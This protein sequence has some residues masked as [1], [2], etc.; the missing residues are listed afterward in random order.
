MS[1][2]T[3]TSTFWSVIALGLTVSVA[4]G[5]CATSPGNG[6]APTGAV[7]TQP[8]DPLATATGSAAVGASE[9]TAAPPEATSAYALTKSEIRERYEDW[10]LAMAAAVA[11][12]GTAS[13]V[14]R[15]ARA[16][17]IATIADDVL[18]WLNSHRDYDPKYSVPIT[19]WQN[20]LT[21]IRSGAR[22]VIK[23]LSAGDQALVAQGET[24]VRDAWAFVG[25]PE[26]LGEW[27]VLMLH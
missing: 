8:G 27:G 6:V 24:G 18:R 1:S 23:G 3:R 26:F 15:K 9:D 5:A 13:A 4:A 19:L 21:R 20:T 2:R 7:S 17:E 22:D 11:A 14:D 12:Y 16:A 10:E 25:E